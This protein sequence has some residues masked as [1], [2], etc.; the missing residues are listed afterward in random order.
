MKDTVFQLTERHAAPS[1][2]EGQRLLQQAVNE[3]LR[4]ELCK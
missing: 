4:K 1:R 2:E 3:W